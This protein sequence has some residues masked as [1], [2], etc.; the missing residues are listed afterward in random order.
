MNANKHRKSLIVVGVVGIVILFSAGY[1]LAYF[2]HNQSTKTEDSELVNSSDV[3]QPVPVST[4]PSVEKSNALH[5]V[6][7]FE[8]LTLFKSHFE[9]TLTLN[10]LLK[11]ATVEI[12]QAYVEQS[13]SISA[14]HWRN[15]VQQAIFQRLAS[16]N[17]KVALEQI[18]EMPIE[19]QQPLIQTI[20]Q[21]WSLANL[22]PAIEQA[23]QLDH[24]NKL[25]ALE[26]ILI[27][28]EHLT[29]AE[30][31]A[32]ARR[33]GNEWLALEKIELEKGLELFEDPE[34]EWND[35]LSHNNNNLDSLDA[36]QSKML[37]YIA[38]AW[39]ARDGI[40]VF[41]KIRESFP[42]QYPLLETVSSIVNKLFPHHPQLALEM[43]AH[44]E[45]I[46]YRQR[47]ELV[48]EILTPWAEIA[49]Q[50]A[51]EAVSRIDGRY[52]RRLFQSLVLETWAAKDAKT[53][54]G[55]IK[56][57]PADLQGIAQE[58]ALIAIAKSTPRDVVELLSE[59]K[60]RHSFLNVAEAIAI[61]WTRQDV[62]SALN[63]IEGDERLAAVQEHLMRRVIT[64]LSKI[65]PQLA[66]QTALSYPVDT[67]EEG[68]EV[69]VIASLA[70]Q[71]DF[72]QAKSY[73]LKARKG[74]TRDH[75]YQSLVSALLFGEVGVQRSRDA[76]D[77]FLHAVTE[78]SVEY[79]GFMLMQI[80]S[81]VPLMLFN[82]LDDLPTEELKREVARSLLAHNED[83]GKFTEDQLAQ[84]RELKQTR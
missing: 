68:L 40:E 62:L 76:V 44:V 37:V 2:I 59:I 53:F 6:S 79:I 45:G 80:S 83:D 17:P 1:F 11:N 61:Q 39:I 75:A 56:N 47:E 82:S 58:K 29:Q 7:D 48:S 55:L 36:A 27:S 43:A 26:G 21:E 64:E 84:L 69:E 12:L 60:D 63:W 8:D 74:T 19:S 50:E 13:K 52:L 71:G 10:R 57:L 3:S 9:R 46:G 16:F 25:S 14:I 41:A 73:L 70:Y 65:E 34:R 51:L 15:T 20:F 32:I 66:F 42:N 4:L 35:F 67:D 54:L 18:D 5:A 78:D 22:D 81:K 38:M 31:R 28:T 49:P 30:R 72:D 24:T 33:L 23:T 77:L